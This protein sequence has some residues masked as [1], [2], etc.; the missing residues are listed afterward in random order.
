MSVQRVLH[1]PAFQAS[2]APLPG[3]MRCICCGLRIAMAEHMAR[4]QASM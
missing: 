2:P 1:V 4:Y 3:T